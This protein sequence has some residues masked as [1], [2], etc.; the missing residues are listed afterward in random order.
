MVQVKGTLGTATTL[1]ITLT[2]LANGAGRIAAQYNG[3]SNFPIKGW[4]SA[5]TKTGSVAPTAG[6]LI[7]FYLVFSDTQSPENITDGLG[8]IDGAIA[9]KPAN[10]RSVG[11]IVVSANADYD[12]QAVFPVF[13]LTQKWSLLVWNA[14]GQALSSTAEDHVMKFIPQ[15]D[16]TV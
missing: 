5:W 10:I 11:S 9:T 13:D 16:E 12:H 3:G 1:S 4:I 14:T 2:S 6:S 7:E 15:Y 8:I